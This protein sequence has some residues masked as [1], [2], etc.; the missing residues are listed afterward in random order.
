MLE[1]DVY[2]AFR[3][4]WPMLRDMID[5]VLSTISN[6]EHIKIRNKWM[7]FAEEKIS[8]ERPEI[9]LTTEEKIWLSENPLIRVSN[10]EAWPPFNFFKDG[11]PQGLSV[12][13]MNLLA[14]KLNL[15][16]VYITGFS[17]S[18]LMDKMRSHELDVMLNIVKTE[19]RDKYILFTDPY[20]KNPNVIVS[21]ISSPFESLSELSGKTV[22]LPKGFFYEEI[23]NREYPEIKLLLVE[24]VL[25]CLKAVITGDADATFGEEAVVNYLKVQNMLTGIRISG[26]VSLG[27]EDFQNLRIGVRGDRP[28]LYSA[29]QKAKNA[30]TSNERKELFSRWMDISEAKFEAVSK[31]TKMPVKLIIQI[32]LIFLTVIVLTFVL[33]HFLSKL[34]SKNNEVATQQKNSVVVITI[35]IFLTITLL[36]TL[37][38]LNRVK[39]QTLS[40]TQESLR[41]SLDGTEE[42]L[43]IWIDQK[44]EQ[45]EQVA[46][47]K[48]FVS[49][50][51]KLLLNPSDKESLSNNRTLM[52]IRERIKT[53]PEIHDDTGFFIINPDN[54]SIGSMR[55]TNL[56][57]TNLIDEQRPELLAEVFT[58]K[59][60]FIPPIVTDLSADK[61]KPTMFYAVPI[62][63]SAGKVV[64]VLTLRDSPA[65][66]LTRLCH[67]GVSGQSL[68]TYAIDENGM[69]ISNSRFD[70]QLREM[71]LIKS[72][73]VSL[74]NLYARDPGGN[75]VKGYRPTRPRVEQP[76]T[77]MAE[78]VVNKI[79]VND[80]QNYPDYRGVE[81]IGLW[82][83]V[84]D[85]N[86]GIAIEID[87]DEAL[88]SY[89]LTRMIIIII[90]AVV[91]VLAIGS[92]IF[93]I[94]IGNKA[95]KALQKYSQSLEEHKDHLEEEVENRTAELTDAKNHL[96]IAMSAAKMGNWVYFIPEKRFE[97]DIAT[98]EIFGIK[99]GEF[100]GKFETWV[101]FIHPD[102]LERVVDRMEQSRSTGAN[103]EDEYRIKLRSGD[104]R[105]VSGRG[106]FVLDQE[107][108]AVRGTGLIW[109]IT[110]QKEAE[111][112]LK[113]SQKDIENVINL[114]P[115]GLAI[116]NLQKIRIILANRE[117]CDLFRIDYETLLKMDTSTIYANPDDRQKVMVEMQTNGRIDN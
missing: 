16:V 49:Y 36:L 88:S 81:V 111:F 85:L 27:D 98:E 20:V 47:D 86:F 43:R 38:G 1:S 115:V 94:L 112:K 92:T 87:H 77:M 37:I 84:D 63:N 54:I 99:P 80:I 104:I 103:Y 19:D 91:V 5:K 2:M 62:K 52:K 35:G 72:D 73:E 13:Y 50:V 25:A 7:S 41:S 82:R 18:E 97:A 74:L 114:A 21:K 95:T 44:I 100:D 45:M 75:M 57:T 65:K 101:E 71:N 30:V 46:S 83:W 28:L 107:G 69:L 8:E 48:I 113:E 14:E 58:G 89:Y 15:Q 106:V 109:D 11:R 64:A 17:W 70:Q 23:L 10:E 34:S 90:L 55:N 40:H 53:A 39:N 4:D 24:D 22:A 116:V 29:I 33:L 12:E 102:D 110:E 68:E 108:T 76:L 59:S 105:Y 66:V 117:I 32:G 51:E 78:S 79:D 6:E 31:K 9:A 67:L 93:S 61:I 60:N 56:G 42:I 26:E 3:K 96:D